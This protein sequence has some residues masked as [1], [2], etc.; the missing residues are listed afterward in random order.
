MT[1]PGAQ[2]S[3]ASVS[4]NKLF[5]L[6][7]QHGQ[8]QDRGQRPSA[9]LRGAQGE[10]RRSP[11]EL[12]PNPKLGRPSRMYVGNVCFGIDSV[13]FS[14]LIRFLALGKPEGSCLTLQRLKIVCPE[15]AFQSLQSSIFCSVWTLQCEGSFIWSPGGPGKAPAG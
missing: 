6:Q 8:G 7:P 14:R 9:R 4:G 5:P 15:F 12:R 13:N 1:I 3:I 2:K 11:G 10:P